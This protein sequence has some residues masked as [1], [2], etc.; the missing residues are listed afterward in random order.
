[1]IRRGPPLHSPHAV[2]LVYFKSLRGIVRGVHAHLMERLRPILR[3]LVDRSASMHGDAAP[4]HPAR[5]ASRVVDKAR[6]AADKMLDRE[7]LERVVSR[8]G[9]SVDTHQK[10]AF[11]RVARKAIYIEPKG[12]DKKVQPQLRRWESENVA[13]IQSLPRRMLDR[14]ESIIHKGFRNA[15][16]PSEIADRLQAELGIAEDRAR[17]IARDQISKL[18]GDLNR[19]RQET[20]GATHY[21]WMTVSDER[22]RPAH[23]ARNGK[24]FAWDDPPG[25]ADDPGDGGH[26]SEGINCRCWAQFIP[27]GEETT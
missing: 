8:V 1:M 25:D 20:L 10:Q 2:E 12:L 11:M 23:R 13:L 27:P 26:P 17:L 22:C 14:V 7:R 9:R 18:N 15:D 24:V 3:E 5:R 4:M 6:A 21:V 16:R 19:H